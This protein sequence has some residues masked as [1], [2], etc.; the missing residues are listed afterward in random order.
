MSDRQL[1]SPELLRQ[2]VRYEPETGRLF[3]LPR[4]RKMFP[5]DGSARTWNTR[6]AGQFALSAHNSKGYL[7]GAIFYKKIFSHRAIWAIQTGAWPI[8]FIDHINGVRDDNRWLNLREATQQQ[9]AKN[10]RPQHG[11][12]SKYLGVW[13]HTGDKK[14]CVRISIDGK[15]KYIGLFACEEEAARAYDA[16]A[17]KYHGQF[18]RPNF[19]PASTET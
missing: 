1:P 19:P 3:W 9:N 15:Q 17:I 14:W 4:P 10:K 7:V 12:S 6:F 18:A 13:R 8:N 11:L 16:A 2:L 5:S